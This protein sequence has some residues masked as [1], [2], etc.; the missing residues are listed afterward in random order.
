MHT[1]YPF[2][3]FFY[4][5]FWIRNSHM[6]EA[7]AIIGAVSACLA[8]AGGFS[9]LGKEIAAARKGLQYVPEYILELK[10]SADVFTIC[11][12]KLASA[13]TKAYSKNDES[14][15]ARETAK[16]IGIIRSQGRKLRAKIQDLLK[17]VKGRLFSSTFSEWFGKLRVLF[18]HTGLRSLQNSL[19]RLVHTTN[20]LCSGVMLDTLLARI[21]ELEDENIPVPRDLTEE[22]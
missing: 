1:S 10:D 4:F 17:R 5:H 12:K 2:H 22:V 11:L 6:A 20:L 3:H 13:A 7:L 9:K 8:L 16:A 18:K 19:D 15:E 14:T 21:K